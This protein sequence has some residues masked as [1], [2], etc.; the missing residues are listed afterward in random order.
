[1][2]S[3]QTPEFVGFLVWLDFVGLLTKSRSGSMNSVVFCRPYS[4]WILIEI[5]IQSLIKIWLES[6]RWWTLIEIP[7]EFYR[8][9]RGIVSKFRPNSV[10]RNSLRFKQRHIRNHTYSDADRNSKVQ[11]TPVGI[12]M[13]TDRNCERNFSDELR[14]EFRKSPMNFDKV[15]S[16]SDQNS[17]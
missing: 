16:E 12:L 5:P 4:Y 9:S 17:D 13:D 7:T 1:M 11:T 6:D 14:L 8:N 3:D 15:R 10:R 2:E